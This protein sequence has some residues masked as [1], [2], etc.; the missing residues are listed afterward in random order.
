MHD[1]KMRTTEGLVK[2]YIT[3]GSNDGVIIR[4]VDD[5]AENQMRT[6]DTSFAVKDSNQIKSATDNNGEFSKE[7]NNINFQIDS[8]WTDDLT[9]NDK[10]SNALIDL[11]NKTEN[12]QVTLVD[13]EQI[14]EIVGNGDAEFASKP[15]K[16]FNSDLTKDEINTIQNHMNR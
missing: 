2:D 9:P 1:D 5:Y 13:E 3:N 14:G 16:I 11:I 4:N 7:N 12:L 6:Y 8:R 15:R 10:L